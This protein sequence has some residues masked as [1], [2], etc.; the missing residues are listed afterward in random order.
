MQQHYIADMA[1]VARLFLTATVFAPGAMHRNASNRAM[2]IGRLSRP[3][4]CGLLC[5]GVTLYHKKEEGFAY[6][7][8]Y[9][10]DRC[11]LLL[12]DAGNTA[13]CS[14]QYQ[15]TRMA[16]GQCRRHAPIDLTR[17]PAFNCRYLRAM[18]SGL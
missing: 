6:S 18:S 13:R 15:N 2:P 10:P 1:Q 17:L 3:I 9:R 8:K 5:A 4:G 11:F 7:H 12:G 16:A 14:L